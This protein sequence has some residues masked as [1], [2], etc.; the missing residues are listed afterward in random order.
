MLIHGEGVAGQ[1]LHVA[2]HGVLPAWGAGRW[3]PR[4][5]L[6]C[7]DGLR[8]HGVLLQPPSS[9]RRA[10]GAQQAAV[11]VPP[12]QRHA[13]SGTAVAHHAFGHQ[14]SQMSVLMA[15]YQANP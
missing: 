1:M 8:G 14:R 11:A 5:G 9:V 7:G 15:L 4:T 6:L 10:G 2:G 3:W 13:A 12:H